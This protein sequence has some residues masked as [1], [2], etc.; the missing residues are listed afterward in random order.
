MNQH[1]HKKAICPMKNTSAKEIIGGISRFGKANFRVTKKQILFS[2]LILCL[3]LL[4]LG[5]FWFKSR[6]KFDNKMSV[7][8]QELSNVDYPVN[9]A[10]LGKNF[11]RYSNR[12]LTII[13]K[14]NTHFDFVFE[15]TDNRT[16]QIVIK[17]VDL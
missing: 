9:P 12:K 15:P 16:A 2:T 7:K 6:Y 14:D 5:G 8:L 4:G 11:Q 10:P 1:Y 3:G 13:N 17:N